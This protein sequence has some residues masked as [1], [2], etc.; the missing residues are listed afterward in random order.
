M[1]SPPAATTVIL[2]F[3]FG[4]TD[5]EP[6]P[7]FILNGGL[8]TKCTLLDFL[9]HALGQAQ[10]CE[11]VS[12]SFFVTT[13]ATPAGGVYGYFILVEKGTQLFKSSLFNLTVHP[14]VTA[15]ISQS[16]SNTN[17]GVPFTISWSSTPA[18]GFG[19]PTTCSIIKSLDVGDG[20]G[21]SSLGVWSTKKVM[22]KF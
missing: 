20:N 5:C 3:T 19:K 22:L 17:T 4:Q 14:V 6:A 18:S 2:E 13:P 9:G 16:T 15:T 10:L 12:S 7:I 1:P 21:Y 11:G 8:T